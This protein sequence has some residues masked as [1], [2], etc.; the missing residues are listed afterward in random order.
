MPPSCDQTGV[1]GL[2]AFA[3]FHS[4]TTSGSVSWMSSRILLKVLPRQSPSSAI[5]LSIRTDAGCCSVIS[6]FFT[7]AIR[8]FSLLPARCALQGQRSSTAEP[9]RLREAVTRRCLVGRSAGLDRD[10]EDGLAE[11]RPHEALKRAG[12]R[13]AHAVEEPDQRR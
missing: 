13:N 4:S 5:L 10:A 3:H 8:Q 2:V 12:K 1:P 9:R 7:L 6:D 11:R